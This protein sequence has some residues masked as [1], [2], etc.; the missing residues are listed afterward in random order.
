MNEYCLFKKI[1]V[2]NKIEKIINRIINEA[3]EKNNFQ[4][5]CFFIISELEKICPDREKREMI[6]EFIEKEYNTE[7]SY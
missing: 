4:E 6:I 2:S 3:N 7:L 5:A 1:K